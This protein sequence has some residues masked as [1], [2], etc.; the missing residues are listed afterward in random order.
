MV[1][2]IFSCTLLLLVIAPSVYAQRSANH[3]AVFDPSGDYHPVNKPNGTEW[4]VQFV[5]QVRH[6]HGRLVAWGQVR[7]IQPWYRFA[8]VSVTSRHLKFSTVHINGVHYNFAGTFLRTGN[9]AAQTPD[10]GAI[11]LKGTLRKFENGR[12]V[13]QLHTSFVYYPGC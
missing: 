7:G 3:A 6:K 2:Q 1:K 9:F 8:S 11:L 10:T 12:N 13:L 4:S 5:L